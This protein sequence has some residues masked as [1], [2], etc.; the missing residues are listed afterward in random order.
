[1]IPHW[2]TILH[3]LNGFLA[4]GV[5]FSLVDILNRNRIV[6]LSPLFVAIVGF[7]FS[8][9]IGVLWEFSEYTLD[10]FIRTDAQ[11]DV[12]VENISTVYLDPL[13]ENNPVYIN[14]ITG[15]TIHTLHGD[16]VVDGGYLDIGLHDTMKDMLVNLI[17]ASCF[18]LFGYFYILD[19]DRYHFVKNFIPR[20][21]V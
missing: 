2:D 5:G 18:S 10:I 11:K 7:C 17:G 16:V 1:M 14:D 21:K 3:T 20:I 13:Q 12:L 4:A 15:V 8:M 6:N 9:T 19:R